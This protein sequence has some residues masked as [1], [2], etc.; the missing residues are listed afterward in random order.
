M[1]CMAVVWQFVSDTLEDPAELRRGI[2]KM[3]DEMQTLASRN[4]GDDEER[5][6]KQLAELGSQADRFLDLY[7]EGKSS[8]QNVGIYGVGPRGQQTRG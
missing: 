5:W 3:L 4:P 6:L 1:T 8:L 7:L 2:D